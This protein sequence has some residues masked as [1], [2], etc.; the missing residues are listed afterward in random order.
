MKM[1]VKGV[2]QKGS[3]SEKQIDDLY[4]EGYLIFEETLTLKNNEGKVRNG[5]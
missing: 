1:V 2:Y 5:G 4:D 3:M